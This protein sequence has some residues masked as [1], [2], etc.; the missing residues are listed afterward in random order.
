MAK[1][2]L[3]IDRDGTLVKEAPPSYRI[4]SFSK[5]EFYPMVFQYMYKIAH[6]F[7]YELVMVTNQDGLGRKEFPFEKFA[8]VHDFII[9][10]FENEEIIFSE[11]LMDCTYPQEHKN[12]R[13][14]GTG[15]L[16]H[17]LNNPEYD[18]AQSFV[19]G[20][21]VTDMQLAKNLNC[22]GFWLCNDETLGAAELTDAVKDIQASSVVLTSPHWKDIYT[23]L[24]KINH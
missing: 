21:R 1:K 23:Y 9:K 5:L 7:N 15:L 10:S 2:C 6:E 11:I 14:P 13:K 24:K 4:D 18:I 22:K 8:P 20:D 16:V 12:T 19:I 3:F 17:Y